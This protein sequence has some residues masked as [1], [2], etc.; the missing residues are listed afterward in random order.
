MLNILKAMLRQTKRD[1]L[2][3]IGLIY[4]LFMAGEMLDFGNGLLHHGLNAVFEG[5]RTIGAATAG[6]RELYDDDHII[7]EFHEVDV[8]T[9]LLEIGTYLFED[10]FDF[11]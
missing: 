2:L 8:A 4:Y 11:A 9:V 5:H 10:V 1:K 7:C 3:L 6:T